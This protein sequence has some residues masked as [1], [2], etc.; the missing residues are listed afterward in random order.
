MYRY[1]VGWHARRGSAAVE[2]AGLELRFPFRFPL[3]AAGTGNL[4]ACRIFWTTGSTGAIEEKTC[5]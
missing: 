1:D 3:N 2:P 4:R 5:D